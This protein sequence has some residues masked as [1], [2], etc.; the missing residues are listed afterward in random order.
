M[1]NG[2]DNNRANDL[3]TK[4]TVR[5]MNHNARHTNSNI[6]SILTLIKVQLSS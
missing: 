5:H 6:E 2:A 1:N 3:I 4:Y